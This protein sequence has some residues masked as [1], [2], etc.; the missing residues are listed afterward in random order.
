MFIWTGDVAQ[1]RVR[2]FIQTPDHPKKVE[3]GNKS[4]FP[5]SLTP[6]DTPLMVWGGSFQIFFSAF[7]THSMHAQVV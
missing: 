2:P 1:A 4:P 7:Q 5:S 6:R 3:T